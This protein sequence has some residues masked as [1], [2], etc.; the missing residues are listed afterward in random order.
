MRDIA[1]P[2]LDTTHSLIVCGK[3]VAPLLKNVS[4]ILFVFLSK[5]FKKSQGVEGFG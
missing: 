3:I 5:W 1:H 2:L 4:S